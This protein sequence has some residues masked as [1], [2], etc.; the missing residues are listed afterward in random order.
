GALLEQRRQLKEKRGRRLVRRVWPGVLAPS[1]VAVKGG[2][3]LFD[4]AAVAPDGAGGILEM[5]DGAAAVAGG[6]AAACS[7]EDAA[8]GWRGGDRLAGVLQTLFGRRGEHSE[9][10][11][12]GRA[13]IGAEHDFAH[14]PEPAQPVGVPGVRASREEER[15]AQGR[16]FACLL[17]RG[18]S[19]ADSGAPEDGNPEEQNYGVG[20]IRTGP[21]PR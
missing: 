7:A 17:Q 20:T 6:I 9:V 10:G 3:R 13:G 15:A 12:F 2:L 8:A 18:L 4:Q 5:G 14:P 16:T 19:A 1:D 11:G 21:G